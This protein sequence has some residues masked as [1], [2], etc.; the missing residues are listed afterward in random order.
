MSMPL[1][2]SF[3]LDLDVPEDELESIKKMWGD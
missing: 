3:D 1:S 2:I